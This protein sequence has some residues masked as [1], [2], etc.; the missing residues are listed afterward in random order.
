MKK[1]RKLLILLLAVV[2]ILAVGCTSENNSTNNENQGNE[3]VNTEEYAG[4][5]YSDKLDDNGFFKDLKALE[6]VELAEYNNISIPSEVHAISEERVQA[7]L[8][9][10][11]TEFATDV[12]IT[13]REVAN[14]DT[15][16]MDYVGS[17]DGVEFEGGTTN[18]RGTEVTIGVTGYIDDFLQQL[19]GHMPGETFDV[20]VTFPAD[21]GVENLNGKDAIF[22]VTINYISEA[23][24]PELTDA[25]VAE[26]LSETYDANTVEELKTVV[27]EQ[28]KQEAMRAYVQ[29]YIM[30]NTVVN[31]LPETV[32]SFQQDMMVNYYQT[33][34]DSYGVSLREFL[35]AYVGYES[36]EALLEA[37]NE[38]LKMTSEYSLII[39]AIAEHADIHV[40]EDYLKDYFVKYTGSEDYSQFETIY[41]MPYLKNLILQE[42][43]LDHVV[44]QAV[45]E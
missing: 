17:V 32:L 29:D 21:Y 20:E 25:F 36:V 16:N 23:V 15:I 44:D 38:D 33:S 43:I 9:S 39:Q 5:D 45:L 42:A 26:N 3:V 7:G 27:G 35:S 2:M 41:G 18:G 24:S 6:H 30:T 28:L 10:I 34:A 31:N 40:T 13:D 37:A 4:I 1:Q 8:T 22:V 11:V 14:F 12:Q 19:I